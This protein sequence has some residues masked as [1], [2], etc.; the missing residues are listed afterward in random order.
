M[1]A[2]VRLLPVR[3]LNLLAQ[4]TRRRLSER[5]HGKILETPVA[6]GWRRDRQLKKHMWFSRLPF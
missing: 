4:L 3:L 5:G 1:S 6:A 2:P